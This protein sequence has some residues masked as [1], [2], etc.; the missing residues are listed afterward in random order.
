[1]RSLR[2]LRRAAVLPPLVLTLW[3]WVLVWSTLSSR[4]D[5]LLNAAFHP[6]VAVAGV[7][8]MLVGL[9]Q[10]RL[11][12][13]RRVPVAPLGWLSS[14]VVA[15]LILFLPPQPSFSD[16][17]ANRPDS[18]PAAP[19]LSFFLPPEQRTLTEWVR[20][21][22]SQP[23][24]ELHAGDP[25]RISGFVLDRPGEPLQLARLTVRCCLADATPAGLP[26]DW[27]AEADPRVDQWFEIEGTMTVQ[28]R[29][30]VPVSVVKPTKLTLIPRPERPLEP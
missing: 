5:L 15:L 14:A 10:L 30:G 25:V 16:L 28:E 8:L 1:M 17:A 12:G 3:G 4:L 27:P 21:L 29:N 20:L 18:L 26:V 9:M 13:R 24:P 7:V 19:T 11:A 23:D 22:R 6:V 2:H